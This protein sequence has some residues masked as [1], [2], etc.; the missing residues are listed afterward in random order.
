MFEAKTVDAAAASLANT[1]KNIDPSKIA[2]LKNFKFV[3]ECNNCSS[4]YPKT[5]KINEKYSI[6]IGKYGFDKIYLHTPLYFNDC[7]PVD[8]E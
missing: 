2:L 5:L 3:S 1:S 7:Q 8:I 6:A 4:V